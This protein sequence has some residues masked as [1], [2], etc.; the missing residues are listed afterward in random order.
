M[1]PIEKAKAKKVDY[2]KYD[3]PATLEKKEVLGF[4]KIKLVQKIERALNSI[5]KHGG[6]AVDEV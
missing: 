4:L 6:K 2:E 1:S 5:L 3:Y